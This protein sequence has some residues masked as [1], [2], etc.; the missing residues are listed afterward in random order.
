M[1]SIFTLIFT[2][3]FFILNAQL[4]EEKT[5]IE[6]GYLVKKYNDNLEL[7]TSEKYI[8]EHLV[9]RNSFNPAN[10]FPEGDFF[11]GNNHYSYDTLSL[12]YADSY[13]YT[14]TQEYRSLTSG[15]Y[16][17]I[18]VVNLGISGNLPDGNG[19]IVGYTYPRVQTYDALGTYVMSNALGF[20][21]PQYVYS[22]ITNSEPIRIDT[23]GSFTISQGLYKDT[24]RLTIGARNIQ[25]A[26]GDFGTPIYYK[27]NNNNEVTEFKVDSKL[28]KYKGEL[29]F[30][31]NISKEN[32]SFT[33][34]ESQL[35]KSN[36]NIDY[37]R[38]YTKYPFINFDFLH[39]NVGIELRSFQVDRA[40]NETAPKMLEMFYYDT[41]G[42]Y[43]T[44]MR[45]GRLNKY[46]DGAIRT[47][48]FKN[49][50]LTE[51]VPTFY[52][53]VSV[54]PQYIYS[55]HNAS[56]RVFDML[57]GETQSKGFGRAYFPNNEDHWSN[58]RLNDLEYNQEETVFLKGLNYVPNSPDEISK[59]L[60][61]LNSDLEYNKYSFSSDNMVFGEWTKEE[62]VIKM[63]LDTRFDVLSYSDGYLRRFN[64]IKEKIS[65]YPS[66]YIA[67]PAFN[68]V[69]LTKIEENN[70]LKTYSRNEL[71]TI[72]DEWIQRGLQVEK[73]EKRKENTRSLLK[74]AGAILNE[75]IRQ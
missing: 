14:V 63:F 24:A 73:V 16:D 47:L 74:G 25:V 9:E 46:Y 22:R 21:S 61:S 50:E 17:E 68:F 42:I 10:G 62:A 35:L 23:I 33:K 57:T 70:S 6:N 45:E 48:P 37:A 64:M 26:F 12:L 69:Q 59:Y 41:E 56:I 66:E 75:A 71:Q 60:V 34:L 38:K 7:V 13:D 1:K 53:K 19:K 18:I 27:E 39:G 44:L 72:V 15:I 29:F 8:K 31:P 67:L 2:T 52:Y 58:K 36:N 51:T 54:L 43:Y 20:K 11:D 65:T 3:A 4:I 49:T 55:G 32:H 40:F 28:F 5:E 30:A